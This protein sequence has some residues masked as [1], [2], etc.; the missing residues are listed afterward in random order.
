MPYEKKIPSACGLRNRAGLQFVTA[1]RPENQA[2]EGE[3]SWTVAILERNSTQ[4][5]DEESPFLCGG[6]IINPNVVMTAAHCLSR[7]NIANLFIR[8]GEWDSLSE[9]EYLPHQ[10]RD[11]LEVVTHEQFNSANGYYDI[12]LLI[13][14]TPVEIAENVNTICLP[15]TT[16]DFSNQRCFASGWGTSSWKERHFRSIMKRIELPI[17]ERTKCQRQL[18]TTRLGIHFQLHESFICAGGEKDIDTCRG[19]GGSPLV[20]QIPN[21][22]DQ[23]YQAGIVSWGIG[24]GDE[25]PGKY[26]S[27]CCQL[28]V[29]YTMLLFHYLAVYVNVAHVREW[30]DEQMILKNLATSDYDPEASKKINYRNPI[31]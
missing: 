1:N 29:D 17:V 28:Y 3:F 21:T 5:S 22:E 9:D 25:V 8:A 27:H 4:K 10:D 11:V 14:K 6:S 20:C 19:D 24:C 18:R 15:P 7:K 16:Y 13:L 30:I 23:Y 31:L 26:I 12:A 2:E